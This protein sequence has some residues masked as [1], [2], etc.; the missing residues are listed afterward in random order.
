MS[1]ALESL[2]FPVNY[3]QIAEAIAQHQGKNA[4]LLINEILNIDSSEHTEPVAHINGV[5]FS[6]L[7]DLTREFIKDPE[8]QLAF[9]K[10]LPF[11]IHGHVGLA[12]M[13]SSTLQEGM[14]TGIRFLYQIMPAYEISYKVENEICTTNLKR[15]TDFEHNNDLI[16]EFLMCALNSFFPFT[17]VSYS[18]ITVDFP[19]EHLLMTEFSQLFPGITVNMNKPYSRFFFPAKFL[20][21]NMI[22]ANQSTRSLLE[23]ELIKRQGTLLNKH[24]LAYQ[25]SRKIYERMEQNL[26]VEANDIAK[27]LN[28]STRT[29]SRHLKTENTNFKAIHNDCRLELAKS[30]LNDTTKNISVITS[31]MGFSSEASFSRYIKQQTGLTPTQ[32]R[33][34]DSL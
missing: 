25:V 4:K 10:I 14:E 28:M 5:Q 16:L 2:R 34:K 20:N 26:P 19:H 22:T 1:T 9:P 8:A 29:L 13:T 23:N 7:L 32:L 33:K 11:T 30:L 12:A 17:T 31:E 6:R 21:D 24:T 3:L 18:D 27:A 15:I